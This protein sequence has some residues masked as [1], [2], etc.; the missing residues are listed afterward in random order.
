MDHAATA[1]GVAQVTEAE[2]REKVKEV[3]ELRERSKA[4]SGAER[5]SLLQRIQTL[6]SEIKEDTRM[7]EKQLQLDRLTLAKKR[8][9]AFFDQREGVHR[10]LSQE[11]KRVQKQLAQETKERESLERQLDVAQ[12]NL[13]EAQ[14]ARELSR[15][16]GGGES[17]GWC[18]CPET[19]SGE[20]RR[21][22]EQI[23]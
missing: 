2:L 19:S 12:N 6:E 18:T 22:P 3:K 5:E 4:R 9:D 11:H 21:A 13:R 20:G 7:V 8:D 17:D 15:G 1:I 14:A 23:G 16:G 10:G